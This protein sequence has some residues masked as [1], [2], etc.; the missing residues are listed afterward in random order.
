MK[1]TEA[2][3]LA[4]A[5]SRS[6][7]PKATMPEVAFAGRSNV[8]KSSLI[9]CL[10]SRKKLANISSLPGKTRLINFFSINHKLGLVDLPGYGYARVPKQVKEGWGPMVEE[11]LAT[12]EK[13]KGVVL[14]M[15]IRR[16]LDQREHD[17]IDFLR[18]RSIPQIVVATK[19]DKLTR[20]G[21]AEKEKLLQRD[22]QTE[23]V[24]DLI[25]FS[26]VTGSGRTALWGEIL[27][28]IESPLDA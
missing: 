25:L 14:V 5:A 18:Q 21:V 10:A 22:L 23:G 27:K 13:L 9:N 6:G 20:K 12:R 7:Y 3:F 15:D 26:S 16:E 19:T 24:N 8:G 2:T 28:T 17:L 1:I 4:S 11:Y